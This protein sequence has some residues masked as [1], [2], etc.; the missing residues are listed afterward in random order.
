MAERPINNCSNRIKLFFIVFLTTLL[1]SSAVFAQTASA[2]QDCSTNS[3]IHCG[4]TSVNDFQK[5]YKN[6]PSVKDIYSEMGINGKEVSH[7]DGN[8]LNGAVTNDNKVVVNGRV[9]AD[10]ALTVGRQDMSNTNGSSSARTKNGTTFYVRHPDVSFAQ[11]SLP[12]FVV[13]KNGHFNFAVIASCGNPVI[14]N[15]T[16]KTTAQTTS[17]KRTT[18][19]AAQPAPPANVIVTAPPPAPVVVNSPAPQPVVVREIPNTGGPSDVLGMGAF[20]SLIG[21][22]GHFLYKRSKFQA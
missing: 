14:A 15:S 7:M 16:A 4:V 20:V 8:T 22:F 9:V 18:V 13:M 1:P 12:A 3:V 2:S 6:N 5:A 10:D 21:G 19:V 17:H 11:D